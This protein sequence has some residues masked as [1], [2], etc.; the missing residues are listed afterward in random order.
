MKFLYNFLYYFEV[1]KIFWYMITIKS[2]K[3]KT[4][5]LGLE[6][7]N[8]QTS[9]IQCDQSF[10]HSTPSSTKSHPNFPYTVTTLPPSSNSDNGNII[11]FS[12]LDTISLLIN[13]RWFRHFQVSSRGKMAVWC[14]S[15][16]WVSAGRMLDGC[17]SASASHPSSIWG[18]PPPPLRLG[19]LRQLLA[20]PTSSHQLMGNLLVSS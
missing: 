14:C 10:S 5:N 12:W 9:I 15:L 13:S 8:F 3:K 17:S 19:S 7:F 16:F 2:F 4:L 1:K 20:P 11:N 18:S 6:S